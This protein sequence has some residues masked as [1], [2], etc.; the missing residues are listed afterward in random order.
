MKI[1]GAFVALATSL[2]MMGC[3]D[4]SRV[5][6]SQ[7][8][9]GAAT[10][11]ACFQGCQQA[12]REDLRDCVVAG[13]DAQGCVSRFQASEQG[14]EYAA[15]PAAPP[16]PPAP[17]PAP[18]A[19]APA[20]PAPPAPAEPPAPPANPSC[21]EACANGAFQV[22]RE[23]QRAGGDAGACEARAAQ[24]A[25]SCERGC[26]MAEPP[27][28][29]RTRA[30]SRLRDRAAQVSRECQRA[31]GDDGACEARRR[32]SPAA[33]KEVAA[34]PS[35]QRPRPASR[36]ARTGLPRCH[37]SVSGRAAM[38]GRARRGRPSSP[39][40]VKE[41]AAWPSHHRTAAASRPVRTGAP[42]CPPSV[43]GPAAM[44]G[45]ARIAS[46]SS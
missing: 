40:A 24:F 39:A 38:P 46:P 29:P 5:E 30:A 44:P 14:C 2:L 37:G 35:P 31:G 34:W 8:E 41:V 25:S 27:A 16:A 36:S 23:C 12:A 6:K 45:P 32:S 3:Q 1:R 43:S 15:A 4:D 19:P 42:R 11:Q 26:G 13:G 33:V 21:Q 20:P 7:F 17:A 9:Q 22:S 10:A 18:P 28:P